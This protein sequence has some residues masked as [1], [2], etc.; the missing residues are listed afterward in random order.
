M[1]EKKHRK[2]KKK[3]AMGPQDGATQSAMLKSLGVKAVLMVLGLLVP[4]FFFEICMIA[5]LHYPV[6]GKWGLL[7]IAKPI[8][9]NEYRSI[10]QFEPALAQYDPEV[11]YLLK[12]GTFHFRNPEFDVIYRVNSAGLRNEEDA[13]HK[14]EIIVL[15][16]S[17]AM[18]WGVRQEETYAGIIARKSKRKVLNAAVSSYGTVREMRL[19]DRLDTSNVRHIIIHYMDN[20]YLENAFF[21]RNNNIFRISRREQYEE[22]VNLYLKIKKYY[23]GKYIHLSL[24]NLLRESSANGDPRLPHAGAGGLQDRDE[25]PETVF[26]NAVMNVPRTDL[27]QVKIIVLV[28]ERTSGFP[29]RLQEEIKRGAYPAYIRNMKVVSLV[30]KLES[31]CYYLLDDHLRARGHERIAAELLD[32]LGK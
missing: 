31:D 19:L 16:D 24:R 23:P 5:T 11:T 30:S 18:G 14:P 21:Y 7:R 27:K 10:I 1:K 4:L 20:D 13:L 15:G 12:P 26:L 29:E 32:T 3:A 17:E 2:Q 25:K 8:Y 6:L 9:E 28:S 22:V